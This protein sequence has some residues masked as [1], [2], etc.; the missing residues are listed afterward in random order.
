MQKEK[1]KK[2][3]KKKK[4][5]KKGAIACDAQVMHGARL[6]KKSRASA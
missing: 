2:K 6:G 5:R 4:K 1:K 3:K